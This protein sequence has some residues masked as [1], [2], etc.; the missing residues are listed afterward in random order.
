VSENQVVPASSAALRWFAFS[1][2]GILTVGSLG[3]FVWQTIFPAIIH[4]LPPATWSWTTMILCAAGLLFCAGYLGFE[5]Y[6]SFD[7][8]LSVEGI[9]A[10]SIRRHLF[11]SW[12]DVQRVEKQ[13]YVYKVHGRNGMI[14]INTLCF[15]KPEQVSR[16]IYEHLPTVLRGPSSQ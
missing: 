16:F 1:M 3:L 8:R 12:S 7:T 13:G 15:R 14:A 2:V 9:S 10:P 6:K 4:G 5:V 11:V